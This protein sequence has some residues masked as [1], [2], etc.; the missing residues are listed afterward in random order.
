[1]V[2]IDDWLDRRCRGSCKFSLGKICVQKKKRGIIKATWPTQ[3]CI[4]NV[5]R[6]IG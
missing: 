6:Y 4:S 3:I 5:T 1:M 2:C